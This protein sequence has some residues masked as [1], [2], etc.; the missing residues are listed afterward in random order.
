MEAERLLK[1][2]VLWGVRTVPGQF[3]LTPVNC[4]GGLNVMAVLMTVQC[5]FDLNDEGFQSAL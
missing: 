2:Q 4:T 1:L 3:Q 5:L